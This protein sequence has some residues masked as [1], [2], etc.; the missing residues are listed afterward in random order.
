MF[1]DN[2]K[3]NFSNSRGLSTIKEDNPVS[4]KLSNIIT[5]EQYLKNKTEAD[6]I[7]YVEPFFVGLLEGDGTITVD[8]ISDRNKRIRIFI[9]LNNLEENRF[10]LNLLVK[11]IGGRVAIERKNSY[12]TWYATS[13]TDLAKV[14]VILA[15]YPLL[16][17]KKICQLEFAK[18][19]IINSKIDIFKEEFHILRDNK[20]KNQ[21]TL[22]NNF[23]NNFCLPSYFSAWLSGFTEAEGHFKLIKYSNNTIRS[24]QFTI[25][26]TFEKHILKAILTYFN[27]EE[28]KISCI[29]NK[30]NVPYYRISLGG[31]DFRNFLITHFNENPLIGDKYT[32]YINW[33]A[34]ATNH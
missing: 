11:Y 23:D 2:S 5:L 18:N 25:G 16:T 19:Y 22:L 20:Y 29:I 9:A 21:E 31:N 32:K 13:K 27:R 14:F 17:T 6:L 7:N 34:Y 33:S 28:I 3:V 8:Y 12:V 4:D 24:S 1:L 26:Q 10:M 15:R 30:E